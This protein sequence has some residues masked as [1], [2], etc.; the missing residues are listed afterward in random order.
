MLKP[1]S[2]IGILGG[3]QLGRMLAM[4]AAR[5][6]FDVHIF[7]PEDN[8]PAARVAAATMVAPYE[9]LHAVARFA[10]GVDVVTYEFENV[11]VATAQAAAEHAPLRPGV[12]ALEVCQD[13]VT[14]KNF[15]NAAGLETTL[16]R[17]IALE[18][19]A[20]T[21][22]AALGAPA[23]L[24]TCRLGYDGK[25]QQV[26]RE[27]SAARE[28]FAALGG[29]PC[30][31]EAFAS[32]ERE[33][34]VVAARG[35]DGAVAAYPLVENHHEGGILRTT[36]APAP[37]A[38]A[39]ES[40]ALRIATG[41]LTGL[42]Y[43]GVLAVEL[44]AM[45]DGRLLVNEVAPRVHN[46]GHWTMDACQVSQFEQHIRAV[47]GWPLG[48]PSPHSAARMENLIGADALRWQ[49][50]ASEP[51]ACVHLYGKGEAREGRKMGHVNRL[52]PLP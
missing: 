42:D 31:L 10:A 28:A 30:I 50:L 37:G 8:S 22:I 46:T 21:A 45:G 14:E 13:R 3:G 19:E 34:S 12:K 25:G 32:F 6:G 49:A 52:S 38:D 7:T 48:D 18:D 40:D 11:P 16:W 43:V 26:I 15:V 5:L 51:G 1:G 35:V 39:L 27:A 17:A 36:I 47:A 41:V 29:V 33:V 4:S 44:F 20:E 23:I 2:R 9:D 24:K